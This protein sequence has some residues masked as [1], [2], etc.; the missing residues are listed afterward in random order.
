M[1]I[2]C[3]DRVCRKGGMKGC[4]D[5][6]CHLIM[7]PKKNF[8]LVVTQY[9]DRTNWMRESARKGGFLSQLLHW[10]NDYQSWRNCPWQI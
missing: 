8:V 6:V 4:V 2:G 3:V 1:S 5:R 10:N 7:T 9:C